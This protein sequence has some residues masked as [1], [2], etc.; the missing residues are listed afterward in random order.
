LSNFGGANH[1]GKK[2]TV[3]GIKAL[4]LWRTVKGVEIF[5]PRHFGFDINYV[6]MEDLVKSTNH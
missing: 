6:P 5:G 3:F 2:V 1:V 4:D